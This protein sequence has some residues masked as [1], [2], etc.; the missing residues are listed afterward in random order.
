MA[1]GPGGENRG[2][3][4]QPDEPARV[5]VTA[6]G[7][8]LK[9]T[10]AEL[11]SLEWL[12]EECERPDGSIDEVRA[13]AGIREILGAEV[14]AFLCSGVSVGDRRTVTLRVHDRPTR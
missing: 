7:I 12:Y 3:G 14:I 4:D 2:P 6:V 13:S 8:N 9:V 1:G 11:T 5:R 10:R